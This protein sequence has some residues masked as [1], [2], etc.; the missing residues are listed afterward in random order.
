MFLSFSL[1]FA[2][3]LMEIVVEIASFSVPV[4]E[5]FVMGRQTH[6]P[7]KDCLLLRLHLMKLL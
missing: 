6:A 2:P 1:V 7:A 5:L 4:V 3:D